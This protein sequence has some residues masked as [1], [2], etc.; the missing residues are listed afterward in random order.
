[1]ANNWKRASS[2]DFSDGKMPPLS[3]HPDMAHPFADNGLEP[4]HLQRNKSERR[5]LQPLQRTN[6]TSTVP[7][8][9]YRPTGW[10]ERFDVW[11]INEGGKRLFFVFFIL[12]HILVIVFG[13][14]YYG[15]S[16]DLVG[17]RKTFGVTYRAYSAHSPS[18]RR[19]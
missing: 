6:T 12:L 14:F 19:A 1:M 10:M 5:R 2:L 9:P 8:T 3:Q 16:D 15:T 11:M 4:S 18:L 17:D 13:A 7:A